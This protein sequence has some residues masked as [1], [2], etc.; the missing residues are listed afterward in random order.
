LFYL[1]DDQIKA[2]VVEPTG[3][4][5]R[6]GEM[7][8]TTECN[9]VNCPEHGTGDGT[10]TCN[11]VRTWRLLESAGQIIF[12]EYAPFFINNSNFD[13]ALEIEFSFDDDD[14]GS[15][16]ATAATPV[17]VDTDD[18]PRVF[19]GATFSEDNVQTA[20]TGFS[21]GDVTLAVQ[22][23]PATPLFILGAA[24]YNDE[25]TISR[26]PNA[27]DGII[28]SILIEQRETRA[29]GD[30]G[31]GTQFTLSGVCNPDA[32]W[33]EID[34]EDLAINITLT[35]HEPPVTDWSFDPLI[36]PGDAIDGAYGLIEGNTLT[37]ASFIE[38]EPPVLGAA[39]PVGF[40]IGGAVSGTPTSAIMTAPVGVINVP[41]N[42][43]GETIVEVWIGSVEV[44]SAVS[45]NARHIILD[46]VGWSVMEYY[47]G[48]MLSNNEWY[49]M[50]LTAS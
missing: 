20:P 1:N 38:W 5:G 12:S 3:D 24:D 26:L 49:T 19:I 15:T 30:T 36:Y 46:F 35:L 44:T 16:V 43:G 33:S 42:F 25:V 2:L 17:A 29:T 14:G 18:S 6:L 27:P 47:I 21:G 34:A 9:A 31:H 50:N 39:G 48:V 37:D 40:V 10:G 22:H 8:V 32:D 45:S 4:L 7:A 11:E 13:V 23:T 41:F 28:Q